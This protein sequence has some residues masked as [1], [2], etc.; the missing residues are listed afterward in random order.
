MLDDDVFCT[1]D[2]GSIF[3]EAGCGV[4]Y[5]LR[6]SGVDGATGTGAIEVQCFVPPCS[7][8]EADLDGDGTV[9]GADFGLL[10]SAW[11]PCKG[12]CPADLDGDGTV[13]GPDLGL[14]LVAWGG[15]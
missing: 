1:F 13:D 9:G 4:D 2:T 3:F 8:C 5:L 12:D 15:C 7:I 10:L 6:I 11:G 14:L